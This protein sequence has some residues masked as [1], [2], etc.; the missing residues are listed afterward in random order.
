MGNICCPVSKP[1]IVDEG[2][3]SLGPRYSPPGR[4]P[5]VGASSYATPITR[6]SM[7]PNRNKSQLRALPRPPQQAQ[8]AGALAGPAE[9]LPSSSGGF[10]SY[11]GTR[12]DPPQGTL[13][14]KQPN[15]A[16]STTL[17]MVPARK[18]VK[19]REKNS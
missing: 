6:T 15:S 3:V 13:G 4:G 12:A 16:K 14:D 17:C 1:C 5:A 9:L 19:C 11:G 7:N 18:H 8:K 2:E 10:R